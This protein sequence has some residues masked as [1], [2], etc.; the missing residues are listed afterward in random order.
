[1]ATYILDRWLWLDCCRK[2][3]F[4]YGR[5]RLIVPSVYF[6]FFAGALLFRRACGWDN[7]KQR[8]LKEP[9][10][11]RRKSR[12][13]VHL[14]VALVLASLIGVGTFF[15][16]RLINNHINNELSVRTL[17]KFWNGGDSPDYENVYK[18]SSLILK[19]EPFNNAAL[20]YH[21]YASFYLAVSQLD[22]SSAQDYLDESINSIRMALLNAKKRLVPQL[23]YMLGKAYFHKN[24]IASYYYYS[25]LVVKYLTVAKNDGYKTDDIAEYLGLS[26]ASLGMTMES[27]ASFTEAL[28]S[29]ESDSLLLSIAEQYNKTGQNKAASQYLYRIINAS[30]NDDILMKSKILLGNIFLEED[31]YDSAE[32]EFNDVLVKNENSVDAHYGLGVIY[33]R[34]GDMVRAR[35]EWRRALRIQANYQPAMQK[36]AI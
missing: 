18:I 23:E 3:I 22:T 27:I 5:T 8:T 36:L 6:I 9:T 19:K 35:A 32:V 13:L 12:L 1:M 14:F 16:L 11:V 31:D 30:E 34:R 2:A 24:K 10:F 28:L 21:G 25:D 29:R 7:M 17:D 4:K 15:G 26:Y 20:T 33:E